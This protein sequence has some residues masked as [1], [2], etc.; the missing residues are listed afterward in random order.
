MTDRTRVVI[1]GRGVICAAGTE[2][3]AI[4]RSLCAGRSSVGRVQQWDTTGWPRPLAGEIRDL[5]PR[6]LV[7]D[8]KLHKLVQRT[9]L[10]GLYSA[11]RAIAEAGLLPHRD[12]LAAAAAQAFNDRTGIYV[13]CGGASYHNQYDFLPLLGAAAGDLRRF[14]RELTATVNPMWLLRVLPNNVLCHLGIRYGFT[15]ANACLT[16]HSVSGLLALTEAAA[17]L[18]AGEAERAVVVGHD[19]PIEPEGI[20]YY[21][22]LGLLTA[23]A[24]RPFDA[25][26]S[27]TLLG[28]GATALVV[29]A[30]AEAVARGARILGEV[31]GG[32]CTT[33][34]QGPLAVRDD[35]DGAARAIDCAL[36]DAGIAAAAVGMIVAHGNGG[37]QS[38]AAE[39]AAI[40]R[41]FGAA[42]PPVTA[43]KWAFGHTLAASGMIDTVLALE[44]LQ[45]GV[46]PGIAT[47]RR[48]D[49]ALG[50]FPV[51]ATAGI[52]RSD[53][54]L[55]IGR[56][57]A[58]TAAAVLV[59]AQPGAR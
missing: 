17:A 45:A 26:R 25:E 35:G 53:V 39:A 20:L 16:T 19:A 8:R 6:A 49:P 7:A 32:A 33:E 27:G 55:V 15:G 42:A 59:R 2:P 46:V 40:R 36:A 24:V 28:E 47:L 4:W 29:E 3:N 54:A 1:T 30:E 34:A 21:H 37:R 57:F 5:D 22:R 9:D 12:A 10:L 58:G 13:G 52:P 48:C 43:Y 51:S 11:G 56:G 23:D 50:D 14:G 18:R 44:S 38:D 41:V 31:L